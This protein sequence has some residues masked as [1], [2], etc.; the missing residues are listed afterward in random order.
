ADFDRVPNLAL[1]TPGCAELDF[2]S[3]ARVSREARV[4]SSRHRRSLGM[5]SSS[6]SV[7]IAALGEL[8]VIFKR[9]DFAGSSRLS[10]A[11]PNA[12]TRPYKQKGRITSG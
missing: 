8:G 5:H 6:T 2:P 4:G 1:F 12:D 7:R 10:D 9:D 11:L 3:Q